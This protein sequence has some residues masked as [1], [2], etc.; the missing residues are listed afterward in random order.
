MTTTKTTIKT[1]TTKEILAMGPY[2]IRQTY[3]AIIEPMWDEA[4]AAGAG[5]E[6][7]VERCR[8]EY[9]VEK[10]YRAAQ[11]AFANRVRKTLFCKNALGEWAIPVS[12]GKCRPIETGTSAAS[13]A[14]NIWAMSEAIKGREEIARFKA[15]VGL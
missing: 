6:C 4:K 9:E 1:P 3:F 7:F 5:I 10:R 8:A 12:Y 15:A 11:A 14:T 13:L 2:E